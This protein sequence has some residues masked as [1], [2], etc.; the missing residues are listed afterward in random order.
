MLTLPDRKMA[1]EAGIETGHQEKFSN[2]SIMSES[3]R[4]ERSSETT[5][6]V[7]I[8]SHHSDLLRREEIFQPR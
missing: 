5:L 8:D 2:L 6:A 3:K 7:K 4:F 1:Y